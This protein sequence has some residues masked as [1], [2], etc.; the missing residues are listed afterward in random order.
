MI[1]ELKKDFTVV[2]ELESV[3]DIDSY[4]LPEQSALKDF[5]DIKETDFFMLLHPCRMQTSSF[6][7]LCYA[8]ALKKP[9]LIIAYLEDLP[10]MALGLNTAEVPVLI[11]SPEEENLKEIIRNIFW[12]WEKKYCKRQ[13]EGKVKK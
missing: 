9:S 13:A 5:I 12:D 2:S 3:K 6:I 10:Y 11:V 8:Y 1:N 7:E 4:D